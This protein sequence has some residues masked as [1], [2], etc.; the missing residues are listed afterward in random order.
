MIYYEKGDVYNNSKGTAYDGFAYKYWKAKLGDVTFPT[1]IKPNYSTYETESAGKSS[2]L[3]D[4]PI[5][6][7][8][9]D[10]MVEI[11][12]NVWVEGFDNECHANILNQTLK[13][14][15]GLTI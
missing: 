11:I 7:V 3:V 4:L 12:L 1:D 14:E 13:I 5:A 8:E 6:D 15:L 2:K 10:A 9:S